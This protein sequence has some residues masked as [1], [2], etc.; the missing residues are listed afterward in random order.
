MKNIERLRLQLKFTAVLHLFLLIHVVLVILISGVF[1]LV[2]ENKDEIK[3]TEKQ[4]Q[5]IHQK[6]DDFPKS[7]ESKFPHN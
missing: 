5:E 4:L 2:K 7:L 3:L 6:G 1:F